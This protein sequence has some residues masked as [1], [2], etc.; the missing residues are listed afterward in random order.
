MTY[1]CLPPNN[2]KRFISWKSRRDPLQGLKKLGD[3][4]DLP[5]PQPISVA[6]LL[7]PV[8]FFF[9]VLIKFIFILSIKYSLAKSTPLI[10]FPLEVTTSDPKLFVKPLSSKDCMVRRPTG[11]KT[12]PTSTGI[13]LGALP[14]MGT[15]LGHCLALAPFWDIF[16]LSFKRGNIFQPLQIALSS[17]LYRL[18]GLCCIISMSNKHWGQFCIIVW[19]ALRTIL[20]QCLTCIEDNSASISDKHWRQ[21][22]FPC[23]PIWKSG[24]ALA[25]FHPPSSVSLPLSLLCSVFYVDQIQTYS[26]N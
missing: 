9:F 13:S 5:E 15:S 21:F 6:P 22:C 10:K 11:A 19:N 12:A 17:Y 4:Q 23:Y 18:F 7:E 2:T 14:S 3:P 26:L 8:M 20:H 25:R 1:L 24:K 16:V